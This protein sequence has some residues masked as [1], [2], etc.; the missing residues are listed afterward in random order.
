[1][2]HRCVTQDVV[3]QALKGMLGDH[4]HQS[5]NSR[6]P[7]GSRGPCW[8]SSHHS[9]SVW[10]TRSLDAVSR[11]SVRAALVLP[12]FPSGEVYL[13]ASVLKLRPFLEGMSYHIYRQSQGSRHQQLP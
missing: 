12:P 4:C 9:C 11:R 3:E 1:M 8:P 10:R 6:R 7:E 5:P 13:E 2:R